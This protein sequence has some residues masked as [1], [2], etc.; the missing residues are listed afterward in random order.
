MRL[1]HSKSLELEEFIG[2]NVPPYAI[3]SHTWV[4]GRYL[5]KTCRTARH[6]R[7]QDIKKFSI[8]VKRQRKMD[9]SMC[10]WI[11]AA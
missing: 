9:L 7:R 4:T 6:P 3:L 1:L 11:P 8:V 5:S 10:G 2:Q